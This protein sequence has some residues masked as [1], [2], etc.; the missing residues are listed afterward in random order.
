MENCEGSHGSRH[1]PDASGRN[2]VPPARVGKIP[3]AAEATATPHTRVAPTSN[4]SWKPVPS[5]PFGE[6]N[7]DSRRHP[8]LI[9]NLVARSVWLIRCSYLRGPPKSINRRK[10]NRLMASLGK[11]GNTY[12]VNWRDDQG[13]VRR[14]STG[15]Q[16]KAEATRNHATDRKRPAA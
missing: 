11:R 16:D 12:Y 9:R 4:C 2:H 14:R 10:G 6:S 7:M 3:R 8:F 5:G 15:C 13:N 1:C